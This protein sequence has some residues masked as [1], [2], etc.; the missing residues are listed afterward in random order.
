LQSDGLQPD[1]VLERLTAESFQTASQKR[2][3][4]RR[5]TGRSTM[6][7]PAARALGEVLRPTLERLSVYVEVVET[8]QTIFPRFAGRETLELLQRAEADYLVFQ[9]AATVTGIVAQLSAGMLLRLNEHT[10]IVCLGETTAEEAQAL[11]LEVHLQPP[12]FS[13]PAVAELLAEN[14]RKRQAA[15]H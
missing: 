14:W 9:G 2:F 11:G 3:G 6:L 10:R 12:H 13:G 8:Y 7:L 4:A 1:L 5:S 15:Q